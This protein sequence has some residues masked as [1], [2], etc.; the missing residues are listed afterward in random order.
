MK[1][2]ILWCLLCIL[3]LVAC[4]DEPDQEPEI[5]RPGL[6]FIEP[7]PSY[8]PE[9][10]TEEEGGMELLESKVQIIPEYA[11]ASSIMPDT[12]S[13]SFHP[14]NTF[15]GSENTAWVEDSP[16]YG[17]GEWLRHHFLWEEE[18]Q[19]VWIYNGHGDFSRKYASISEISLRFSD[20]TEGM[21]ALEPGWNSIILPQAVVTTYVE[22]MILSAD[23]ALG[24]NSCIGEMR[25]FSASSQTATEQ[26]GMETVLKNMGALGDCSNITPQQAQAFAQELQYVMDWAETTKAE[27]IH[28]GEAYGEYT[29]E[30]L[31]FA[32]GDGIPVLYYDYDFKVVEDLFVTETDVVVWDGE[33]AQ[34]SFF[35]TAGSETSI[36]WILPGYVYENRGEY[37]FGLTE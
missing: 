22:L 26:L 10:H 35:E 28:K 6:T 19:E 32:G 25:L 21:Y 23:T 13:E 14:S 20:G 33:K 7:E 5:F 4:S 29:G 12:P 18:V 2:Q 17:L 24:E 1:K 27:R 15:D 30:A 34:R 31:L 9:I 11:T 16:G 3:P 37:Y 8:E 36:N